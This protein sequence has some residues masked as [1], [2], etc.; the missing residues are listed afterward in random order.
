MVILLEIGNKTDRDH[1]TVDPAWFSETTTRRSFYNQTLIACLY[2][3]QRRRDKYE[4]VII[5]PA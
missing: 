5:I 1:K 4:G 2:L 3:A